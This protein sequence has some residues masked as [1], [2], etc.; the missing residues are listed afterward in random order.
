MARYTSLFTLGKR[1]RLRNW[2]RTSLLSKL[3]SE[4]V[5]GVLDP[6]LTPDLANGL[7][8]KNCMYNQS[9]ISLRKDFILSA[10][11]FPIH[12]LIHTKAV[13]LRGIS[14]QG[15]ILARSLLPCTGVQQALSTIYGVGWFGYSHIHV[16]AVVWL[17]RAQIALSCSARLRVLTA[18]SHTTTDIWYSSKKEKKGRR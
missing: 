4:G 16:P 18:A 10:H 6:D 5:K 7:C 8:L 1:V 12:L 14:I 3:L 15:K 11:L 2:E 13:T 9:L 17:A